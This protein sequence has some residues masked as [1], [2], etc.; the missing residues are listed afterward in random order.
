MKGRNH[1]SP[2]RS[3]KDFVQK[4]WAMASRWK[5]CRF[6]TENF[7]WVLR[8]VRESEL[9]D[10][11]PQHPVTVPPFTMGKFEVTQAQWKAIASL[12][13]VKIDLNVDPSK[14]KGSDRPV[15]NVSWNDA[16]EFCDRLSAKTGKKYRLPSE[17]EWEYAC[18]AGTTAPFNVGATLSADLANYDGTYTYGSGQKGTYRNET[19]AVG[20]FS[21]N[22]F[23]LYD[24]H[25]NVWEWC[26]DY[27]HTNYQ[28]APTDGSAWVEGGDRANRLLRGGS[29]D[30]DPWLCRSAL[31]NRLGPDRRY[32]FIGF[33]VVCGS[34]WT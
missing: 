28:G 5:W 9:S 27:Y 29:W 7:Q 34:A 24:M 23:G 22:A 19:I 30:D 18:R 1:R 21:P 4:T 2:P 13:K 31:R 12:P 11:S 17:A 33:R 10:E 15:E 20:S 25:G 32:D 14:F 6:Q 16:I 3:G 8:T 26:A